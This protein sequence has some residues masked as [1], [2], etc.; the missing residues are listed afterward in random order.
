MGYLSCMQKQAANGLKL[1]K[2]RE[3]QQPSWLQQ[4]TAPKVPS[5]TRIRAV[6]LLVCDVLDV[7]NLL[8][9]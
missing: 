3:V 7:Q 1:P 8:R 4:F 9:H 2:E 5:D 6:A